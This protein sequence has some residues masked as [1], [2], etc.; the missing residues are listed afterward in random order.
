V[1][2]SSFQPLE[3]LRVVTD[4]PALS[5]IEQHILLVCVLRT[6]NT[7]RRVRASQQILAT[8]CHV[9]RRTVGRALQSPAVRRYFVMEEVGNRLNLTWRYVTH[10]H[11]YVTESHTVGDRVSHHLPLS[12]PTSAKDHTPI[13]RTPSEVVK[14]APASP[15]VSVTEREP[16]PWEAVKDEDVRI[17]PTCRWFVPC[18]CIK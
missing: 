16:L 1:S 6:D 8:T 14:S 2:V 9:S 10:S 5:A 4:D 18:G 17:C 13:S 3:Q 7:T 12:A 11:P 15:K